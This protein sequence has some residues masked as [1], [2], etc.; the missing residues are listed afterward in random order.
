MSQKSHRM[1]P[2]WHYFQEKQM[3]HRVAYLKDQAIYK[4]YPEN[5]AEWNFYDV[6]K[7]WEMIRKLTLHM[8]G[9]TMVDQLTD[10]EIPLAIQI[11]N[12]ITNT[13]FDNLDSI[14]HSKAEIER[15]LHQNEED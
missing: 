7:D 14:G 13:I 10:Q 8:L 11:A 9:R 15:R 12:S 2:A 1:D 4:D 6:E 3:K 5:A